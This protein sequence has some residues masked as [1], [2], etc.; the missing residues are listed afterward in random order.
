MGD[1]MTNRT[2][3]LTTLSMLTAM[4]FLLGAFIRIRGIIPIAPF[5]TYDAKDVG[6][7]I[8]GFMFGPLAALLMSVVLALLEMVTISDS[9]PI[10]A[11]MN[12]L[13][14]ASFACTAAA[15]Y[16]RM[17]NRNGAI[18]GLVVGSLVA[19]ATMLLWNYVMIPIYTPTITR[20]MV[21]GLILPGLLPFNLIKTGINSVVVLLVYKHVSRALK[22]AGFYQLKE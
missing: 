21:A 19:T 3:Q 22:A 20:Q 17:R 18:I 12:T 7:L 15:I 6:I 13:A 1:F 9:G 4:S 14:S 2:K 5:L 16:S 10:G 8:G 11:I